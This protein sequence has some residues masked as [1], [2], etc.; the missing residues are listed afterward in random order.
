VL[1]GQTGQRQGAHAELTQIIL[2]QVDALSRQ[3]DRLSLGITSTVL[4][5]GKL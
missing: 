2:E 3:I 4:L 1:H 5:D